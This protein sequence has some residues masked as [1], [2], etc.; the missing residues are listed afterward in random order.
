M[1][2]TMCRKEVGAM[3]GA[4]RT[5]TMFKLY[6]VRLAVRAVLFAACVY[7]F[8]TNRSALDPSRA[9]GPAHGLSF[10]NVAFLFLVGDML[11]KFLKKARISMG[12]LK[13]YRRYHIPTDETIGARAR[14]VVRNLVGGQYLELAQDKANEVWEAVSQ[15][16]KTAEAIRAEVAYMFDE[17]RETGT[18]SLKYARRLLNNPRFLDLMRFNDEYLEVDAPARARLRLKRWGEIAP[19]LIFWVVFN[20]VIAAALALTGNLVAEVA[21]LWAMFYFVFDVFSVVVWCPI[22]IWFMRNRCCA[23]CQIF[24]WDGIMAATPLIFVG[25]WFGWPI[26]ALAVVVL[27]R[28]EIAAVRHPERFDESTNARL[29]CAQ[30]TEQLCRIRG[31]I[32]PRAPRADKMSA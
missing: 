27:L 2:G 30:C 26:L 17:I 21:I 28:W 22:Q 8:I 20:A 5:T 10:L 16:G 7:L 4:T 23:T 31:K 18:L 1:Q 14:V 15:P 29:S 13:Q 6:C 32:E 25:G 12:S 19:V 11:T 24:N 3:T 9:F